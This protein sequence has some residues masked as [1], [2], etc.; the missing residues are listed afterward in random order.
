MIPQID[1]LIDHETGELDRLIIS[2]LAQARA[3][4][5]F[6]PCP[7]PREVRSHIRDL[8]ERAHAMRSAWHRDHGLPSEEVCEM[9]NIPAWGDSGDSFAGGR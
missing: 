1:L 6:G 3:V 5:D 9:V 7:S 2:H 4:R 8:E